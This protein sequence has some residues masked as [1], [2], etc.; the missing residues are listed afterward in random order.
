MRSKWT[1]FRIIALTTGLAAVVCNGGAAVESDV[2][3]LDYELSLE[4]IYPPHDGKGSWFQ[5]RPVAIPTAD[6][7]TPSVVMT[8]QRAI[9]S[10]Y[11]TGLALSRTE[12]F[13]KTWTPPV[14][15]PQLGWRDGESGLKVGVCDFTQAWHAA[16]GKVIGI[17]HTVRYTATGF[18]GYGNRRD[19]AYAI[20]DPE[21][22][23][24]SPWT[25]LAMP[26][27]EDDA[28]YFNGVH[29][30]WLVEPDGSLLVPI[31][32]VG[33]DQPFLA[34]GVVARFAF[35]G[36]K[37][38]FVER[39]RDV[40][41]GVKRGL[42]EKSL[43]FFQGKYY[44]TMRNDEKGFVAVS[45]DG[46]NFGPIRAWTFDDGSDLGSY[47]T[48]QKWVTH[49]GGL[50][51]VYTRRGA[52][53][54]HIMRHRA[55]LFI[56]Q[57]DPERRCVIRDTERIAVPEDGHALG[58]FDATTIDENETWITVAGGSAYCARIRWSQPNGLAGRVN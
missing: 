13:G 5:P 17:G 36:T 53:N 56:A 47:N 38:T 55:P 20:Y 22:D 4:I 40:V 29:G 3:P 10:D 43:T 54:D 2:E 35:D 12:D 33:P 37:L 39:G 11:F 23:V 9:G 51:L 27:T 15:L 21:T 31:Y 48:Q 34:K 50:F 8:I 1:I 49:S 7:S 16:T 19:T 44:M 18:A 14:E 41:H 45:D 42:Y 46:L 52:K 24:W 57:V 6:G 26:V 28:Y 30:Q 32:Y 25:I 58:N